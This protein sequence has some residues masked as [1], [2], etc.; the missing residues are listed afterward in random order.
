MVVLLSIIGILKP[1]L[2]F[3][4]AAVA[5]LGYVLHLKGKYTNIGRKQAEDNQARANKQVM[6]EA[7]NVHQKNTTLDRA[8][9]D[10]AITDDGV[11]DPLGR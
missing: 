2:P 7:D 5:A 6:E 9:L 3:L 1:I 4:M 11:P 10:A 8:A